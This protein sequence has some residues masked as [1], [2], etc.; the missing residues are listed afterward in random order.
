MSNAPD[1]G[2]ELPLRIHVD[3][4]H[5]VERQKAMQDTA[6]A[7]DVQLISML[8]TEF[9]APRSRPSTRPSIDTSKGLK[10]E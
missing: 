2:D 8:A 5:M 1:F 10:G 7:R 9:R 3:L 6:D 4:A